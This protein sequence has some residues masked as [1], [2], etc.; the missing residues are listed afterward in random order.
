[1]EDS[2]RPTSIASVESITNPLIADIKAAYEDDTNCQSLIA[3]LKNT[4]E[5][6]PLE[7]QLP[8]SKDNSV[9]RKTAD[10]T[11]P[12]QKKTAVTTLNR[13]GTEHTESTVDFGTVP[14]SKRLLS[15]IHRF[16]YEDGFLLYRNNPEDAPRI[17]VPANEELRYNIVHEYH[18]TPS[19][20]HLGRD[21]TLHALARTFWWNNMHKFVD[22][23]VR[24]CDVCQRVKPTKSTQAPLQSLKIPEYVW[25]DIGLDYIFGFPKNNK[26]QTGI[27]VFICRLSKMVHLAPCK[28]DITAEQS[29]RLFID[30]VYKH[31]GL[32]D[33]CG[34]ADG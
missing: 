13:E 22:K 2:G 33:N 31:H 8:I 21:K 11:P 18:G 9:Q 25:T 20:G 32:P 28:Q 4:P 15:R 29:A 14:L 24:R 3:Y 34:E 7:S 6:Q 27:L 16:T 1:V 17:V 10:T 19:S 5:R 26:N 30:H 23:Y 12:V